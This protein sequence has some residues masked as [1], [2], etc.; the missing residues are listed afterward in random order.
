MQKASGQDESGDAEQRPADILLRERRVVF[1]AGEITG[2]CAGRIVAQLLHLARQDP[3]AGVTLYINTPGGVTSDALAIYDTMETVRSPISTVCIGSSRGIGSL[4]LAAGTK[5]QRHAAP[6]SAIS[7]YQPPDRVETGDPERL[8]A[9]I[10]RTKDRVARLFAQ[11]TGKP[12]LEIRPEL[13]RD[14]IMSPEQARHYGLVD[15]VGPIHL[16]E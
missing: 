16:S 3:G 10:R 14:W 7:I 1:L 8:L 4:I 15:I 6:N 2:E 5:G 12:E 11:H 9:R 13:D